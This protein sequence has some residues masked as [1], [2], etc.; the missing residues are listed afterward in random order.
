M[1]K[2]PARGLFRQHLGV[3]KSLGHRPMSPLNTPLDLH[4]KPLRRYM[5]SQCLRACDMSVKA[6]QSETYVYV[7]ILLGHLN[8]Q[9]KTKKLTTKVEKTEIKT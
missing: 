9:A 1:Q 4:S 2:D 8:M 3:R 6:V 5:A 7:W